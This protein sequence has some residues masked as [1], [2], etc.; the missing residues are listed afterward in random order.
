MGTSIFFDGFVGNALTSAVMGKVAG[1]SS[2]DEVVDKMIVLAP[3]LIILVLLVIFYFIYQAVSDKRLGGAILTECRRQIINGMR[4][5]IS[6]MTVM[7]VAKLVDVSKEQAQEI[8]EGMKA[9]GQI[10]ETTYHGK[11]VWCLKGLGDGMMYS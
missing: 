2:M 3:L 9:D 7:E 10:Y 1:P 5:K 8:L 6:G 4:Q 11:T